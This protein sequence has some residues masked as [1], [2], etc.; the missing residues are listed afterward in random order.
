M[1][2]PVE[3]YME[4]IREFIKKSKDPLVK[5]SPDLFIKKIEEQAFQNWLNF[6]EAELTLEQLDEIRREILESQ[7]RVD[8]NTPILRWRSKILGT[9]NVLFIN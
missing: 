6:G 1:S 9:D 2:T 5:E 3:T 4:K 7:K 8:I